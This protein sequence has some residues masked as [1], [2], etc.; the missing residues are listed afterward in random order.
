MD[1]FHHFLERFEVG[2]AVHRI[3]H[4]AEQI[5]VD[6]DAVALQAVRDRK[7]PAILGRQ[8]IGSRIQ[9]AVDG[10]AR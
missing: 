7:D 1:G 9:L 4:P 6:G 5:G 3:A 8:V 2:D 10:S